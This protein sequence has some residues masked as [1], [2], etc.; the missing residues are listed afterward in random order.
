MGDTIMGKQ[1]KKCG[2]YNARANGEIEIGWARDENTG[3]TGPGQIVEF[4]D[5]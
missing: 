2:M 3:R 1:K 4:M 5:R